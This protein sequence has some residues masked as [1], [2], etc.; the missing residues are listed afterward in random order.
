MVESKSVFYWLHSVRAFIQRGAHR[1]KISWVFFVVGFLLSYCLQGKLSED[2]WQNAMTGVATV[3][4]MLS[5]IAYNLRCRVMDYTLKMM[6]GSSWYDD[7]SGQAQECGVRLTN[8][9]I[10]S[11]MT[12]VI[13]ILSKCFPECL[14]L[15]SLSIGAF[16]ACCVQYTHV[17]LAFEEVESTMI[18]YAKK[19]R[20]EKEGQNF[21]LQEEERKRKYPDN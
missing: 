13:C 8:I 14:I 5:I 11:F 6:V 1:N 17:L 10:L 7:L 21:I 4:G 16:S 2:L 18:D 9:V 20:D 12:S 15:S 19:E 3:S